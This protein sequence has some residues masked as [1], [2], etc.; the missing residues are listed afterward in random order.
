M[1]NLDL[2]AQNNCPLR[3]SKSM[4]N[5]LLCGRNCLTKHTEACN[6]TISQGLQYEKPENGLSSVIVIF[7]VIMTSHL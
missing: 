5:M 6:I 3:K 7:F 4:D 2:F 1:E